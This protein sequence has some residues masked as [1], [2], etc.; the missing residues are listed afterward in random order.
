MNNESDSDIEI[1]KLP[2]G[3]TKERV[4]L[5]NTD[6][7]IERKLILEKARMA[8]QMKKE[9]LELEK[10]QKIEEEIQKRMNLMIARQHNANRRSIKEPVYIEEDEYSDDD[11]HQ[12]VITVKKKS[13]P[14]QKRIYA[15]QYPNLTPKNT[16][17]VP[18]NNYM[19]PTQNY[20]S[21]NRYRI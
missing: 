19:E 3:S 21:S 2:S 13:L 9:R 10:Q 4:D 14:N 12:E 11:D 16:Y 1:K 18:H 7:K 15:E 8:K 6:S 20:I 17:Q 5:P